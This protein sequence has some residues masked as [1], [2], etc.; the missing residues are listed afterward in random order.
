MNW[1]QALAI[2]KWDGFLPLITSFSP[3]IGFLYEPFWGGVL[4]AVLPFVNALIRAHIA[5]RQIRKLC[6]GKCPILRQLTIGVA[7][8]FL[9]LLEIGCSIVIFGKEVLN[10]TVACY[11]AG[12]YLGY[13]LFILFSLYPTNTLLVEEE[14]IVICSLCQ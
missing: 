1:K 14:G 6:N 13:L 7:I 9:L 8:I 11:G 2:L 10:L 4:A 12:L 3:A 5:D